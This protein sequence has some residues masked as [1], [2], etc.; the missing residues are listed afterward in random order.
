MARPSCIIA[1]E[2]SLLFPSPSSVK[3]DTMARTGQIPIWKLLPPK[4]KN[5]SANGSAANQS[6]VL[7]KGRETE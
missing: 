6:R 4:H 5:I 3:A 7:E 2:L 1:I